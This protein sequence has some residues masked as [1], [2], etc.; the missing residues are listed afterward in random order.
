MRVVCLQPNIQWEDKPANFSI[1]RQMLDA[2]APQPGSLVVL[3]EMFSTG[4]SMNVPTI[5]ED[6]PSE[7]VAFLAGCARKFGVWMLGG[8][9]TTFPDSCGRNEAVVVNPHGTE[10]LRYAKIHPFT[11]GREGEFYSGGDAIMT[12]KWQGFLVAPFICY[13]LRFPEVFRLAMQRG[14]QVFP[15]I[16][17]WPAARE[18]HWITLLKARAIENQA[19]VVGVNRCGSNLKLE[20]SGRSMII[21][22]LGS[23]L[24]D[25]GNEQGVISADLDVDA[26]RKWRA[27]F[28]ALRD[29]RCEIGR[30]QG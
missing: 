28:P 3:P 4:F 27:E 19:Y 2:S 21:D 25:A 7:T 14:A 15:V 26:L 20:Y 24:A 30:V 10:I 8:L 9:V 6:E 1:I 18:A 12:F 16:A 22:P 17:N 23:V 29:M 11:F 13:D 5:A